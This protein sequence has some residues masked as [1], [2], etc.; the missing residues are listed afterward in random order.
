MNWRA[1]AVVVSLVLAGC[2]SVVGGNGAAEASDSVS[3]PTPTL[4]PVSVPE[5]TT[6]SPTLPPGV[7]GDSV[8]DSA[9]LY[10]AHMAYLQGR[11]Y[12]LEVRV[13][14][15]EVRS[16]RLFR[17]ETPTRYYR[18]DLLPGRN[19][20]RYADDETVYTRTAIGDNELFAR[21]DDV[22]RPS[23]HTIRLSKAFL[24]LDEVRV[25]ET[26]VDGRLH[27]ELTGSYPVHPTVET[28][29][30]VSIAA[31]VHPA[32]F[33][34][35]LNVSYVAARSGTETNVTRTFAYT[36]VGETTVERPAWVDRVPEEGETPEPQTGV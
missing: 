35:S 17:V 24:Q 6:A 7:S 28:L 25:A 2:G 27:Y 1:V 5:V 34:R 18:Q 10:D 31:V 23:A 4:T 14:A 11:S 29:R 16:E 20:T 33:I 19:F 8:T 3:A 22:D 32:G 15:D 13:R 21:S 12:T 26:L 9:A 36:D 30:N